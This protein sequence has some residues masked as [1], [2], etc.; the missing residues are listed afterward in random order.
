MP[1]RLLAEFSPTIFFLLL[2]LFPVNY[3]KGGID[4]LSAIY[5]DSF[6]AHLSLESLFAPRNELL[7]FFFEATPKK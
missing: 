4:N 3:V 2:L 1:G 6:I 5:P 7:F